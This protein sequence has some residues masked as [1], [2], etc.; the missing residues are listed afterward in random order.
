MRDVKEYN[1]CLLLFG[2]TAEKNKCDY[3][4]MY[5]INCLDQRISQDMFFCLTRKQISYGKNT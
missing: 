1:I 4:E 2:Y 5:Q 3:K